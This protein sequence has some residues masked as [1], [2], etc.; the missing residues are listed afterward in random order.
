MPNQKNY[1][2]Q[3]LV[4]AVANNTNYRQVLN[5]LGLR[6]AGGNY[7]TLRT[8]IKELNLDITHMKGQAHNK[9]KTFGPKRPL[10]DYLSNKFPIASHALK[11]RLIKENIKEHKCYKCNLNTWLGSPIPLELEHINGNHS[12]NQLH[13]LTL[14]CPNC[15]AQT[16]TYRGKNK[17]SY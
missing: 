7:H 11:G 16:P 14:L 9:G 6:A 4:N 2:E 13:N 10:E 5:A 3:D 1:T 17:G 12:D 15:H 8:K